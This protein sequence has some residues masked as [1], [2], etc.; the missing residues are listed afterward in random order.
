MKSQ[1]MSCVICY[2]VKSHKSVCY[3]VKS[4]ESVMCDLL[5]CEVLEK[6]PVMISYIVKS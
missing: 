4:Q 5:H 2:V 3:I 6:C 1:E